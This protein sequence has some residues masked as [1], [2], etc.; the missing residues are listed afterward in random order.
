MEAL[1][2]G[3]GTLLVVFGYMLVKKI[4]KSRCA[5]DSGCLTC[6]SPAI[7]LAKKHTE[8]LDNLF[9]IIKRL[10]RDRDRPEPRPK[11]LSEVRAFFR[12][13]HRA[14]VSTDSVV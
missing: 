5:M 8:R 3:G 6:E 13:L 14:T 12:R 11:V 7:E 1:I 4:S 10:D 9:D 2:A